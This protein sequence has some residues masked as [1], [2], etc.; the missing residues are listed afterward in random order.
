MKRLRELFES[1]AY[2]GMKP[3]SAP[4]ARSPRR[5]LGPLSEPV[6]RFLDGPG[7]N[8]PFYL[9]NRTTGQK[10]RVAILIVIPL[11]LVLGGV[12]LAAMGFFDASRLPAQS[13]PLT[14]SE[15]AAKMLP[16]L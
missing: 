3:G 5:W 14:S 2:A 13:K 8:D 15:M 7:S 9:S 4:A 11:S 6:N 1:I 10:F 12:G 16:N